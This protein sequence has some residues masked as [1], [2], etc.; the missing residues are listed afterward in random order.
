[1]ET[2]F[3]TFC[4][5]MIRFRVE[6]SV[7]PSEM[8]DILAVTDPEVDVE[9]IQQRGCELILFRLEYICKVFPSVSSQSNSKSNECEVTWTDS[10]SIRN[11]RNSGVE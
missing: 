1:M 5:L 4:V 6:I 3:K 10:I 11:P 7:Q 8:K 2:L 9:F